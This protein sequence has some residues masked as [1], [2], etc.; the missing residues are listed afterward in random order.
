MTKN[1]VIVESPAK[2]K[3]IEKFLGKDFT[4]KSSFGHIR[5]LP[6][7]GLSVDI[8]DNFRP[9]YQ[10]SPDKTKIVSELKKAAKTADTIWLASDE[11]REGEAIAWHL[12]EA[13]R[14]DHTKTKRIVFHEITEPAIKAAIKNPRNVDKDL[15]DAQQARRV[16]DRLVGYELSPVLWKKVQRGLS[17]GRVQSVA[18]RLIVEREREI[19]AFDSQDSYKVTADFSANKKSDLQAE[20]DTKLADEASAKQ[21]LE[22]LK[23]ATFCVQDITQKPGKRSPSPPFTTSTLQQEASRRLGYSV[24]QT[25]TLAQ[26]LYE[27]G[28]I[29]YMRTDSLNLSELAI[30]AAG[31]EITKRYGK[32]LVEP[33]RYKTKASGAQEAHEAIRPTNFTHDEAGSDT[34]QK[35][36]YRLIWQRAMASQMKQAEIKK[37]TVDIVDNAQKSRFI[38]KGEMVVAKG[39]LEV[40]PNDFR[41][42]FLPELTTGQALDASSIVAQQV[43]SRPPA[44]YTE[45]SLVKKL[46]EMGIGRPSTYAPTISTIQDRGYVE[47]RD[48]DG[49]EREVISLVLSSGEVRKETN[50][51]VT[52]A[53]KNKLIP[54][55]IASVVTDFLTKHF[56]RV[57]DYKFTAQ[58]EDEFDKIADG[59]LKWQ[60][61]LD[62]FYKDFHVRVEKAEE[63]SRKDAGGM[64]KLGSDPKSKRPVFARVGRY[65][66]MVQIGEAEDEEKPK[67]APM[68]SGKNMETVTLEEAL[69]MFNLPRTVG[70]TKEGEEITANIGRFGPYVK[71]GSLFVSIKPEDPFTIDETS[72]RTYIAEKRKQ[73][74]NK[75]INTFEDGDV[76][77][78]VLNGRYGPY[79]TDGTKNAKIPKDDDPKKIDIEKA[80]KLLAEA[81]AKRRGRFTKKSS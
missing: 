59:A 19:N 53:D 22:A 45:A 49:R 5:D 47:K 67:F 20:L 8:E 38:A 58:V 27:S 51:E 25:M 16:L 80:K 32:E 71:V 7:K 43:F 39:W 26:R 34:Q 9:D 44:R 74:A 1:L 52:G 35:K 62:K 65:G 6:S 30:S 18:V 15:V 3:T 14:L 40:Y 21:L 60:S 12:V 57:T 24:R 50:T 72:A 73:E 54:T 36:L 33:R 17:A 23:Q 78:Q 81:P 42:S 28:S 29:T 66:P 77:I 2:A 41:E 55:D 61:M 48:L 69:E 79:V 13:L 10:V 76:T 63:I 46:E 68:P 64:R 31:E 56:D 37:T 70:T 4:V 11:D 75:H